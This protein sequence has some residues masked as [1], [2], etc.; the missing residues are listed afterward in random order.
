MHG[1]CQ[2]PGDP[3][4]ITNLNAQ[5]LSH[6]G[7]GNLLNHELRNHKNIGS[8]NFSKAHAITQVSGLF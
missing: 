3:E 4:N 8:R 7:S 2:P 6:L 1:A 5:N